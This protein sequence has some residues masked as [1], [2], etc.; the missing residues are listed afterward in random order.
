VSRKRKRAAASWLLEGWMRKLHVMEADGC[1]P[2]DV[3]E[4]RERARLAAMNLRWANRVVM[5]E[6]F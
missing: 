6:G 3:A 2:L 5:K 4:V 1:D